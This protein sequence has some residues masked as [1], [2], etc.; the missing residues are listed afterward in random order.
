MLL[1]IGFFFIEL[2]ALRSNK[3]RRK[4]Q[5]QSRL[6]SARDKYSR[7]FMEILPVRIRKQSGHIDPIEFGKG[8]KIDNKEN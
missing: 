3:I 7:D 2:V 8:K 5:T 6:L 4:N 1:I